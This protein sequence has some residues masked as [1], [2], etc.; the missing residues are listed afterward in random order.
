MIGIHAQLRELPSQLRRRFLQGTGRDVDRIKQCARLAAQQ[1]L[2]Q[3]AG[4]GR[5]PGTELDQGQRRSRR[6][7]DLWR[8]VLEDRAFGAR[9]VVLGQLGDLLEQRR[10]GLVIKQL[11]R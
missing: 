3:D 9:Q 8:E 10:T 7:K 6:L 5:G 11:R 1:F 4:L 2:D